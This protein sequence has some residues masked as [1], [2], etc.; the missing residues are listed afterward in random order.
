[1]EEIPICGE[2][3]AIVHEIKKYIKNLKNI[4]KFKKINPED[5]GNF[6][7]RSNLYTDAKLPWI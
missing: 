7:N 3:Y 5:T 1:M 2:V 6:S 4:I